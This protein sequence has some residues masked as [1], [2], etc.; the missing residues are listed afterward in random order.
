MNTL[1]VSHPSPMS[2]NEKKT[3]TDQKVFFSGHD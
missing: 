1:I 2:T 3:E